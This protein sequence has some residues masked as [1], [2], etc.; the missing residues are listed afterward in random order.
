MKLFGEDRRFDFSMLKPRGHY[1]EAGLESYFR[2]MSWLGRVDLRIAVQP[3]PRKPWAVNRRALDDALLLESLFTA[4]ARAAWDAMDQAFTALVGPRDS[5]SLPELAA[6]R[7]ALPTDLVRASD[8]DLV[9]VLRGPASERIHTQWVDSESRLLSFVLLGQRYAL[10][11]HVLS[12]VLYGELADGDGASTQRMMPMPADV[13]YAVFGNRAARQ[14]LVPEVA[15]W[16]APYAIALEAAHREASTASELDTGSLYHRWLGALRA[17]SPDRERDAGLP[18]PF[19]SDAWAR[20]MLNTQL[21]SWAELRH[22]NLLYAKPTDTIM[23]TCEYPDGYVDPYPAFYG[24]M[25]SL[26]ARGKAMVGALPP[27]PPPAADLVPFFD[28]MAATMA[29]LRHI[30][31]RE[32][33]NQPLEADDLDFLNH[34]VSLDGKAVGCTTVN[35][36]A[37]WYGH[38]YYDRSHALEH[39]PVIV[40]IHTQ[41]TD[42]DADQL[43]RVLHVATALPRMMVVTLAHD[44]GQHTQTYR[45]FVSTYQEKTT[46]HFQRITD[47]EWRDELMQRPAMVLP[48]LRDVTSP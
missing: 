25:E 35:E 12:R 19:G 47:E 7:G 3:R 38:L 41:V 27:E 6:V 15:V 45:G 28:A 46:D 40:D 13:G 9:A 36:A 14:L 2:A 30:A 22:D 29:Q 24:A 42:D 4:R 8:S 32:R 31:E 44:G 39:E 26:A 34:M 1:V 20:R 21:A 18:T 23:A 37:G 17:L 10:D 5:M 33:A 16:G 43:G 48:W 11:S